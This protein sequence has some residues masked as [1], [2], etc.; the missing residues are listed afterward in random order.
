MADACRESGPIDV[1]YLIAYGNRFSAVDVNRGVDGVS[2]TLLVR[3]REINDLDDTRSLVDT[4]VAYDNGRSTGPDFIANSSATGDGCG[5]DE[6]NVALADST[7]V[8]S[9]RV[10]E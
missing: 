3:G 7:H 9:F 2:A 6:P 4:I 5:F 1:C 8:R 10:G